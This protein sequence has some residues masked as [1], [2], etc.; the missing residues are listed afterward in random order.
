M[1]KTI[2]KEICIML[3]L[4]LAVVLVFGIV[5]YDYIPINKIIPNKVSY[6]VPEEVQVE[7]ESE[8]L[9][10]EIKPEPI[11]YS[12]TTKDLKDYEASGVYPKGNPNPFQAYSISGNSTIINGSG[13]SNQNGNT[14]QYYPST[15][16]K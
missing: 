2:I 13:T 10:Q 9:V 4:C 5:F 16:T 14:T 6:T 11:T 12:V 3:L 1:I 8:V 7:L 15:S